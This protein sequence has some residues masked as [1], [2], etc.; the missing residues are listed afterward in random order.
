MSRYSHRIAAIR[1]LDEFHVKSHTVGRDRKLL[2][3][4]IVE[5][6]CPIIIYASIIAAELV[7]DQRNNTD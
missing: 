3:L 5:G 2:Q 6:P 7:L 4:I 1:T